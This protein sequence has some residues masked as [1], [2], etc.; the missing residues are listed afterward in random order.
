MFGFAKFFL[1]VVAGM[2]LLLHS[3]SSILLTSYGDETKMKDEAIDPRKF[4]VLLRDLPLQ[5]MMLKTKTVF[6]FEYNS[7]TKETASFPIEGVILKGIYERIVFPIIVAHKKNKVHTSCLV[8]TGSPYTYLSDATLRE[9]KL[10]VF[11]DD[12]FNLNVHGLPVTVY[13]SVNSFSDINLCGQSFFA[14]HK[15]E[16]NVNYRTRKTFARKTADLTDSELEEL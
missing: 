8:D 13:R 11:G 5:K 16:L 1:L 14:E 9:L 7:V 3:V 12:E 10:E 4:D 2:C 6:G 15:L